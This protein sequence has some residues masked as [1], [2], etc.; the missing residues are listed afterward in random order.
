MEDDQDNMIRYFDDGEFRDL[1]SFKMDTI[2]CKTLSILNKKHK[3]E[4]PETPT[5]TQHA[6]FMQ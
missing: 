1:L 6:Q 3:L 5:N 4:L 2:G